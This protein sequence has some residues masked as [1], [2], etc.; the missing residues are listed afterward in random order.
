MSLST[1]NID[2][3]IIEVKTEFSLIFNIDYFKIDV[4]S[5]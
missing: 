1:Y 4:V 3:Q 5:A 2:F